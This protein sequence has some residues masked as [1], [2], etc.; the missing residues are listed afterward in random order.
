MKLAIAAAA[1]TVLLFALP[2]HADT[3]PSWNLSASGYFGG[4]GQ[5]AETFQASFTLH[6]GDEYGLLLP[7]WTGTIS[8]SGLLGDF[9]ANYVDAV[10][11]PALGY[12]AADDAYGDEIDFTLLPYPWGPFG[13]DPLPPPEMLGTPYLWSC[14]D[15]RICAAYGTYVG[16][17]LF[18]GGG[19]LTQTVTRIAT[20]E[21][22][23]FGLLALG[24]SL[25]GLGV[26]Y[27][28]GRTRSGLRFHPREPLAG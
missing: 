13:W 2:A 25:L 6:Y 8:F 15:A 17:G 7:L 9:T 23:E 10:V 27:R 26:A 28:S 20:P 5:P 11:S 24:I 1:L 3:L 19:E 4:F 12:L 14:Q 18:S 22:G 21:P 16:I